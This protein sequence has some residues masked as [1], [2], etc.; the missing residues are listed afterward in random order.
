MLLQSRGV[1]LVRREGRVVGV[2]LRAR[3][4]EVADLAR[5]EEVGL[6]GVQV[7][8]RG[9]ARR[10]VGIREEFRPEGDGVE[11]PR[12]KVTVSKNS[13]RGRVTMKMR[14]GTERLPTL[15]VSKSVV[16][17]LIVAGKLSKKMCV[18]PPVIS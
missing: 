4:R 6:G 16:G 1:G 12:L 10:Q 17:I 5:V 11:A 14:L 18:V 2:A 8:A 9:D 13:K 3:V 7:G 15:R